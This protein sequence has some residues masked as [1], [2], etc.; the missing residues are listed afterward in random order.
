[1]N[2]TSCRTLASSALAVAA[3]L[4]WT[5]AAV[6]VGTPAGTTIQNQATVTYE[7]ANANTLTELSNIVQ[8]TVSQVAGVLINPDNSGTGDPGDILYYAHTVTNTGNGDD[9]IDL[10]AASSQGW[11]V[12]F[13]QD[14]DGDGLYNSAVDVPLADSD[15]DGTP[16]TGVLAGDG[17]Y[18]VL[19]AVEIPAGTADGTVDTTT[20]TATST[21]DVTVSDSAVDTTNA[22]SPALTVTKSV[23]PAGDQPPGTTL[24]YT[25]V[26]SNGG[27]TG[28]SNVVLTDPVP[29]FTTYVAGSIVQDGTGLTDG[30]GD[31]NGD[32]GVSNAG[33]VTVDVGAL[34]A[35]ASTTISF[36]VTID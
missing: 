5:T 22:Q 15:G 35:G 25:I 6:A 13:Y 34:A 10:S 27:S 26:V 33:T 9:T 3:L 16:D 14:V 8:T 32:F 31:D 30:G 29:A 7:D 21:F 2:R 11:T 24:T 12:T 28:A 19:V 4:I 23:A 1:M 18:Q 17:T 36:Q 20:V